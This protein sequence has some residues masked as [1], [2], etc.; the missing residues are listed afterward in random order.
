MIGMDS[1]QHTQ[2]V[3]GAAWMA[4]LAFASG[5]MHLSTAPQSITVAGHTWIG[6]GALASV[7]S[8]NEGAD[9]RAEQLTL[10]LS[11]ADPAM[12]AAAMGPATE[13]RGRAARLSLQ[14][15]DEAFL[16]VGTPRLR[17]AGYMARVQ[18][19]RRAA[20]G[21]APASG[22]IELICTRAGMARARNREGLRL[23]HAQQQQRYPGDTGL[24][25]VRGLIEKPVA[26]LSKEFQK[27]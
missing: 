17:W 5:T 13:Y 24:R 8:V 14:L 16:P 23:T 1:A 22:S 18:V 27:Q 20:D 2:A 11:L 4:E 7:S 9:N 19:N 21:D 3:V 6:L 12:L 15:F 25:Y 10:S 26:W